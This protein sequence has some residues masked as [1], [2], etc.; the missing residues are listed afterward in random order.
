M[1]HQG[2]HRR[3]SPTSLPWEPRCL[4]WTRRVREQAGHLTAA[5]SRQPAVWALSP[6]EPSRGEVKWHPW[7]HGVSRSDHS[8]CSTADSG[9]TATRGETAGWGSGAR[10]RHTGWTT[11]R[12]CPGPPSPG[13]GEKATNTSDKGKTVHGGCGGKPCGRVRAGRRPFL[14]VG[15]CLCRIH[16]SVLRGGGGT[17]AGR[18]RNSRG[19]RGEPGQHGRTG[20]GPVRAAQ[21][22]AV[23]MLEG[24]Q[25]GG[26]SL[27]GFSG[28]AK[29]SELL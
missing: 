23:E 18:S 12:P 15:A 22:R 11:P 7:G 17:S 21:G 2:G 10:T 25:G 8:E 5:P 28:H 1:I 24:R 19:G 16:V 29:S 26:L 27:K 9:P 4:W 13:V 3:P 14:C 6:W 20:A